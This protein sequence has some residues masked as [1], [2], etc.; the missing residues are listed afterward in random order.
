MLKNHYVALSTLP[1]FE[2][3]TLPVATHRANQ[4]AMMAWYNLKVY[5]QPFKMQVFKYV[6]PL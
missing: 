6:E 2:P 4:W 3:G 1:G 5:Q